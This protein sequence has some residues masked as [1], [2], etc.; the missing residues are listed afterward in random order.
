MGHSVTEVNELSVERQFE[1]C[2]VFE[3]ETKTYYLCIYRPPQGDFE[4][5]MEKLE[6]ALKIILNQMHFNIIIAGD[7]N[8][9]FDVANNASIKIQEL[10]S[11]FG[12]HIVFSEPSRVTLRSSHC[13]DN[14]FTNIDFTI[15][16][17]ATVNHHVSDHLAQRL[18][19]ER[20][21]TSRGRVYKNIRVL[22]E[23]SI[24]LFRQKLE[25]IDGSF[26][27]KDSARDSYTRLHAVIM[28]SFNSCFP[29]KRIRIADK[30][31]QGHWEILEIKALKNKV[32]A[33]HTIFQI[34]RDDDSNKLYMRLK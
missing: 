25:N 34:K 28:E 21:E 29:E 26:I 19:L 16:K 10:L 23:N 27:I 13:I 11:S 1:I 18:D 6:K 9:Y 3:K 24:N 30:L 7:F 2:A 22:D 32:D 15:Y 20:S 5:F 12:L 17:A 14:F 8:V 4:L 31:N 33:A